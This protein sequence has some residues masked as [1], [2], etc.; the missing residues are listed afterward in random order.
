MESVT[1]SS[2]Y[3]PI[4]ISLN[5]AITNP[6]S[7]RTKTT[8]Q[9]QEHRSP[10]TYKLRLLLFSKTSGT[11]IYKKKSSVS[12]VCYVFLP[13]VRD[14]ERGQERA[15]KPQPY[16]TAYLILRCTQKNLSSSQR[17]STRDNIVLY[18]NHLRHIFLLNVTLE[19]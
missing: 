14:R 16:R 12:L 8:Q 11:E 2:L 9:Y 17:V 10:S 5:F 4:S 18:S 1:H 19:V 15:E 7:T 3:L 13:E 6:T